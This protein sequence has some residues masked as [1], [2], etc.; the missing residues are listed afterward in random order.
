MKYEVSHS[1]T[2]Q[3]QASVLEKL[4][5]YCDIENKSVLEIG[6]SMPKENILAY[7]PKSWV[8]VDPLY[9]PENGIS[10]INDVDNISEIKKFVKTD[11]KSFTWSEPFDIAFSCN[12]F[13][14]IHD[15]NF[16]LNNIKRL[17]KPN[18][19]IYANFGPIWSGPDG[20]H[21]EGFRY[22]NTIY[23]FW[24]NNPLPHWAHLVYTP[25]ELLEL[26]KKDYDPFF[27]KK[28]VETVYYSNWINRLF[29]EEYEFIITNLNMEIIKFAYSTNI[30][31][32]QILPLMP[33]YD[34]V[35]VDNLERELERRYG[36]INFYARD[37]ELILRLRK[38]N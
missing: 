21:I 1:V 24:E 12:A 19:I 30:D 37:L 38:K 3:S 16:A 22:N 34:R 36:D 18:G 20:S 25:Q 17:L 29:F 13:H 15:L 11:I 33:K 7:Y 23:N 4:L 35:H 26:L 6:G 10:L 2:A 5:N 27:A 8:S 31:Y 14:H 32:V 28:L 9:S